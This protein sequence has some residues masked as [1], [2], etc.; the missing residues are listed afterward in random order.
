MD[1]FRA[2]LGLMVRWGCLSVRGR[3]RMVWKYDEYVCGKVQTEEH[4]LFKCNQYGE[5][6]KNKE[7]QI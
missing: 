7:M 5:E 1:V 2:I 4:V 3:E 6:K